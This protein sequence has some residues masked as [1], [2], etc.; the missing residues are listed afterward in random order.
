MNKLQSCEMSFGAIHPFYMSVIQ[1]ETSLDSSE[2]THDSHVHPECEIYINLTGDVSFMVERRVYPILP[3]DIIITR[4]F[5]YHHCIYHSAAPH[6]HFWILFSANGNERLFPRFFDRCVGDGNLLTLPADRRGELFSLCNEM[7]STDTD[8]ATRYRRFFR[9]MSLLDLADVS[10]PTPESYPPD[11]AAALEWINQHYAEAFTVSELA[12]MAHVSVNTLERHFG[13]VLHMT[14]T[15][16][17]KKKRLGVAAERL[18]S[19]ASVSEACAAS[20][21]SDYSNFIALFKRT[22]GMTPLKYK[23][24]TTHT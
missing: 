6:R 10:H 14:P 8:E 11:V 15:A 23:K 9:L 24:D 1:S 5:E 3:G 19:G 22:Y 7:A 12:R 16:Y 13:E 4:P 2:R 17:L 18:W 21:F 20:G